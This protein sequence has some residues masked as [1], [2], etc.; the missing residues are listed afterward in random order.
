MPNEPKIISDTIPPFKNRFPG[1]ECWIDPRII[2]SSFGIFQAKDEYS[3][4]DLDY[5]KSLV[6]SIK[7]HL[8]EKWI[9]T[10]QT[11]YK[12]FSKRVY[13]LSLEFL[14]AERSEI[15]SSIWIFYDH[16]VQAI[17]IYRSIMRN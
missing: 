7:D 5:Y 11:Y 1:Y 17:K 8:V 3:A 14:M 15:L 6:Y 2:Q 16:V 10:Q 4:T 9:E 12:K 13:Y